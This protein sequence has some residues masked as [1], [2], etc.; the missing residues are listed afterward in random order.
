MNRV[1]ISCISVLA[2]FAAH[3]VDATVEWAFK[4]AI[5]LDGAWEMA[6]SP[7][8]PEVD[9]YP[10][11]EGKLVQEAIPGYWEDMVPAF[12]AA[13][14]ADEFRINPEYTERRLP[15]RGWSPDTQLPQIYGT[16]YYRRH[17]S[18]SRT[19]G[20]SLA[21]EGV[22]NQ[23][24][25]WVNGRFVECRRGYSTPFTIEIPEG[26]LRDGRNEIVLAVA[27]NLNLGYLGAEVRGLTSRSI[28][29]ATGG[30]NG[31]LALEFVASDIGNVAVTTADDLM[32]FTI[33]T[34]GKDRCR[35]EIADGGRIVRSGEGAGD[36]L[37]SSEG[38]SFWSPES[39][40]LYTLR[41]F[42]DGRRY[43]QR[44]GLRRLA[45]KGDRLF[46]NGRP[47]FL[48]GV[49]E[50]C[51]FPNTVHLPRD[52]EYYRMVTRRRKELG[53]NFV[54]FHTFI[55]PAEYL[56]AAD[57][58]G[59]MIEIES[60]NFVTERE[61][62]AI[63]AFARRHPS[64]VM[65]CTG[66]ETRIDRLAE[67]YLEEIA[68]MVHSRTDSLFSPMS[69][70]KG[71]SYGVY[72]AVE[73]VV[74]K[75]HRHN[76]ERAARLARYSDVFNAFCDNATSYNYIG[77]RTAA[78]IDSWSPFYCRKPRLLH[79]ICIDGTYADLSLEGLYP[80]DSPI[81][82][83]GLF[84]EVRRV[85]SEKGLVSRAGTY[86]TN[87]CAWVAL[88]RK[89]AFE[90][91][92]ACRTVAGFDFLG[93]I[94]THWHTFGYSVGMMDEFY[95]LKPH[96]TVKN[97]LRY[98]S[99]A[100]LLADFDADFVF[101]SR[102]VRNTSF[103]ISNFARD[104]HGGT[105]TVSL[106]DDGG[107][108]VFSRRIDSVPASLGEVTRLAT[109]DIAF[110]DAAMPQRLH[111]SARLVAEGVS[112][113]NRW[114][115]YVFPKPG[116]VSGGAQVRVCTDISRDDLL[117]AMWRGERVLL[118]G[119]GPFK[120]SP[121]TFCTG[122]PGRCGGNFATVVKAGHPAL[123]GFPHDGYCSWQ[124]RRMM[125]G[126][127]AFQLES[128][129]PFDPIIDVASSVKL[130]IRQAALFEYRVGGGRLLACSFNL[131]ADDPAGVYLR[132][133]LCRYVASGAF[134]PSATLT[135][136]D[137]AALVDTPQVTSKRD[138]NR[139]MNPGD[140]ARYIRMGKDL[141]P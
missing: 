10:S 14:I 83:T 87:S 38:M 73:P 47:V 67:V 75:P 115:C 122:R 126:A 15:Q 102:K 80:K 3:A 42:R 124:F 95:R 92:R 77:G 16:F 51:Y 129:V 50:H 85:L 121:M 68:D 25:V 117:S 81:L 37:L 72:E 59:M 116:E 63:I 111:L 8:F 11:F 106:E 1:A 6:Y 71:V 78:E 103:S 22:R 27:N 94:N 46:L 79:E 21:F 4:D 2:V 24:Q 13:G 23:V 107:H 28:F 110:P 112:V 39:P 65:Y 104:M 29:R 74:K 36:I 130:P 35:Y 76:E 44:F 128:D 56:D 139:A 30:V 88:G 114:D 48:R 12:R 49:T 89:Y 135:V 90:K 108:V 96:E 70:L 33:H 31:H 141:M 7:F 53:F 118:L 40:K 137:L 109:V 64:V 32:S 26:Y 5:S 60:P 17:I 134:V 125:E 18:L 61:Y 66:N 84:S 100:V 123:E 55:P 133:L 127:S 86:F 138:P 119:K 140:P 93:D 54:R 62:A 43:Q 91:A 57:E 34:G 113:E 45:A 132:S 52:V 131:H 98:N 99:S 69:A 9:T 101:P 136:N 82:R 120:T 19:R 105:L 20:A 97:V 41:L 58:G